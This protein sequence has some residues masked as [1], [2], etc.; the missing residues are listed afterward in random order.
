MARELGELYVGVK[1]DNCGKHGEGVP[2]DDGRTRCGKCGQFAEEV[3]GYCAEHDIDYG[4]LSGY[5]H[6]PMC[7]EERNIR[8][9][10]QEIQERRANPR[11][12][13]MVDAPRW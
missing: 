4:K 5:D 8:A 3:D 7:R 13:P 2:T 1:C 10:E 6:C 11:M 9:R 12:H